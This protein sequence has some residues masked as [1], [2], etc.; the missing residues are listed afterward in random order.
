MKKGGKT[1]FRVLPWGHR[2]PLSSGTANPKVVP[3]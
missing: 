1:G 3:T 2:H